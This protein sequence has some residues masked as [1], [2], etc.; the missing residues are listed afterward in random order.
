MSSANRCIMGLLARTAAPRRVLMGCRG[1]ST[2][3]A[4]GK[5]AAAAAAAHDDAHGGMKPAAVGQQ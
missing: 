1:T 4:L 5:P 3:P 2:A